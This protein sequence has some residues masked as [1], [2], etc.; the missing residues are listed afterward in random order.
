MALLKEDGSLDIEWINNLPLEEHCKVVASFTE[1][2]FKEYLS[3]NPVDKSK[4]A[5]RSIYTD[6]P[7]EEWGVDA[8]E[9]L[10]KLLDSLKK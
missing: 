7:I 2:Q 8:M 10:N 5:P 4:N 3:K 9:H 1:K 6:K